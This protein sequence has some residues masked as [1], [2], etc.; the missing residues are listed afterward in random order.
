MKSAIF[1][2]LA[3]V[4]AATS[5]LAHDPLSAVPVDEA[6]EDRSFETFRMVLRAAVA[7]R[8]TEFVLSQSCPD[9]LVSLGGNGGR[10]ELREFLTVP[11]ET[12][13]DEYKPQAAAMREAHWGAL[14]DVLG[15]G[16]SFNDEGEFWAPYTFNIE[17]PEGWEAYSTYFVTG[18]NVMFRAR[19][20]P[21]A[22]PITSLSHVA[23]I[24]DGYD[25]EAE[26]Q[27][28]KLA[29]GVTGYIHRDYIRGVA[30]HRAGFVRNDAGHWQLCSFVA[31]L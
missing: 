6:A 24:V 7:E 28:A 29:S 8:N 4:I 9:I 23:I 25:P 12:L 17:L 30:D 31:G 10:E 15:M 14:E 5:A 26:Y 2:T 18:T 19:P 20:E 22:P 3:G 16:G 1:A 21:S 27:P 13:S 11:E